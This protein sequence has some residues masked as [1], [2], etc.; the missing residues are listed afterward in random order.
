MSPKIILTLRKAVC[1]ST[2]SLLYSTALKAFRQSYT[3]LLNYSQPSGQSLM[4]QTLSIRTAIYSVCHLRH[5][6]ASHQ[7]LEPQTNTTQTTSEVHHKTMIAILA[8]DIMAF[9]MYYSIIMLKYYVEVLKHALQHLTFP[10]KLSTAILSVTSCLH[11][12]WKMGKKHALS[13]LFT[14]QTMLYKTETVGQDKI[15]KCSDSSTE[16]TFVG[17]T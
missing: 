4:R 16:E 8:D 2:V 9:I 14:K 7:D 15:Q 6:P 13:F 12:I 3:L 17:Q 1:T 10:Y 5:S 11:M